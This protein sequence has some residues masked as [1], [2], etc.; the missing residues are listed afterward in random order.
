MSRRVTTNSRLVLYAGLQHEVVLEIESVSVTNVYALGGRSSSREV[1]ALQF[2]GHEP[3]QEEWRWFDELLA[4][5]LR[6]LGPHWLLGEAKDRVVSK[7]LSTVERFRPNIPIR[8][9]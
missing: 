5:S 6:K 8:I 2:F 9:R 1:I 4:R 3:T 7:M